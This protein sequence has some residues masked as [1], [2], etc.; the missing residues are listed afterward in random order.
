[1]LLSRQNEELT[2]SNLSQR[3]CAPLR[4]VNSSVMDA[5]ITRRLRSVKYQVIQDKTRAGE[6]GPRDEVSGCV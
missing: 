5:E 4:T 2:D 1:M 6:E 3:K